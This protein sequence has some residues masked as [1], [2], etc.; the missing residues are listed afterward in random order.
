MIAWFLSKWK[1]APINLTKEICY[2]SKQIYHCGLKEI[3]I[4]SNFHFKWDE[5]PNQFFIVGFEVIDKIRIA[6]QGTSPPT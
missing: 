4:N 1:E 3:F 2:K 6:L 5:A